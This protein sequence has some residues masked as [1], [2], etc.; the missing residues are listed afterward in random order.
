MANETVFLARRAEH[1]VIPKEPWRLR[2]LA[3]IRAR[4]QCV[5]ILQASHRLLLAPICS[6]VTVLSSRSS[7]RKLYMRQLIKI[8]TVAIFVAADFAL[9]ASLCMRDSRTAKHWRI[10]VRG[11]RR[12]AHRSRM[13]TIDNK[14]FCFARSCYPLQ[15]FKNYPPAGCGGAVGSYLGRDLATFLA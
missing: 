4:F 11:T 5:R 8:G 10:L 1:K 12:S 7:I 6:G 2:N 9:L 15:Q 14:A 13:C 3:S